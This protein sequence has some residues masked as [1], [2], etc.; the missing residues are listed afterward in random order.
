MADNTQWS[1]ANETAKEDVMA[2][3]LDDEVWLMTIS[4]DL[5]VVAEL[6]GG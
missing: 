2:G 1:A 5:I 4:N 6:I 3:W